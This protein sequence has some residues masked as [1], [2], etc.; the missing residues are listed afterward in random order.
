MP[1]IGLPA[2]MV[3][4]IRTPSQAPNTVGIIDSASSQ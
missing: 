4:F 2:N 3:K 1:I